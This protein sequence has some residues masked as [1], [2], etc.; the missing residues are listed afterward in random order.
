M[1]FYIKKN[2]ELKENINT[3]PEKNESF[4]TN[5]DKSFLYF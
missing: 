1:R 2:I 4:N 3:F 5:K